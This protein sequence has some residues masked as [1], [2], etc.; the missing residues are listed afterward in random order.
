MT[1]SVACFRMAYFA[2]L[3]TPRKAFDAGNHRRPAL[4]ST[5][6]RALQSARA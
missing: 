3:T 2:S 5:F 6:A 1:V 4:A